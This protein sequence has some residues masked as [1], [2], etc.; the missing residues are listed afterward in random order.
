MREEPAPPRRPKPP[1]KT[2]RRAAGRKAG[3]ARRRLQSRQSANAGH[4]KRACRN[5]SKLNP[6]ISAP[7]WLTLRASR[8]KKRQWRSLGGD[9]RKDRIGRCCLN[10][11]KS[12][13]L[14]GKEAIR[15]FHFSGIAITSPCCRFSQARRGQRPC[16]AP[17]SS[18]GPI[19]EYPQPTFLDSLEAE[20]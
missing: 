2:R 1:G 4:A 10:T 11:L 16:C 15:P 19:D 17:G 3:R 6:H 13:R 20:V 9:S 8:W 18:R 12:S 7:C 14:G 5:V